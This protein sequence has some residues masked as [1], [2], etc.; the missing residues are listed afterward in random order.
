M[1]PDELLAFREHTLYRLLTRAQRA[2]NDEMTRRL[3]E[4]SYPD[5]QPSYA[6]VLSNLHPDGSSI[7]AV[8]TRAGVTRQAASQLLKEIEAKGYVRRE[9]DPKDARAVIVRRTKRGEQLLR[10]A[11]GVVSE[12]EAEYAGSI[13]EQKVERLRTLLAE[14]LRD[15]DPV[16]GL[17]RD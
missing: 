3:Q 16:G 11:L 1:D 17:S 15:I 8:A 13:G 5:V 10:D 12:L 7:V 2:H 14:L 6:R 9:R 4:R